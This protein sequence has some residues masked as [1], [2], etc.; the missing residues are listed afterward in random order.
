[1]IAAG[2]LTLVEGIR[3]RELGTTNRGLLMVAALVIVRFFDSGVSFLVRGLGF[4]AIGLACFALNL[5]LV[6]R[7]PGKA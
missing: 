1:V 5:W 2:T 4:M 7:A 6:R 3:A